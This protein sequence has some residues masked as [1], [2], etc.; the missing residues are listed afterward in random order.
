M[1][2]VDH[3]RHRRRHH[4]QQQDAGG[5]VGRPE[6]PNQERVAF[7]AKDHANQFAHELINDAVQNKLGQKND[8]YI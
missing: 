6:L 4:K 1:V 7:H 2:Q 3:H 5:R 8:E